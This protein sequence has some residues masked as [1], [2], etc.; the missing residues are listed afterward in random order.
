MDYDDNG[1]LTGR[2]AY[3]LLT[4]YAEDEFVS[5]DGLHRSVM[6]WLGLYHP[7][8]ITLVFVDFCAVMDHDVLHTRAVSTFKAFSF[9]DTSRPKHRGKYERII[10]IRP[11]LMGLCAVIKGS[12]EDKIRLMF[13]MYGIRHGDFRDTFICPDDLVEMVMS[14]HYI[15]D[16]VQA[17]RIAETV[18]MG[19]KHSPSRGISPWEMFEVLRHDRTLL[20]PYEPSGQ[21]LLS[22]R[23]RKG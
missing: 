15:D 5:M 16:E 17:M 7:P 9:P 4:E 12:L 11:I 14:C 1:Q 23:K 10:N 22:P 2:Q 8:S 20:F 6:T 19:A 3:N 18:F 21:T 13:E